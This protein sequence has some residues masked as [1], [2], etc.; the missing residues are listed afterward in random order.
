[1]TPH[2]TANTTHLPPPRSEWSRLILKGLER[3]SLW[4][5]F[6]CLED[7][8]GPLLLYV[9]P[10]G[11]GGAFGY[12]IAESDLG[13]D[14]DPSGAERRLRTLA[15]AELRKDLYFLPPAEQAAS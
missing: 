10:E 13:P 9:R 12:G 15:E 5:R 11:L 4:Q 14:C 2:G 1:M 3:I 8:R 7:H 6:E